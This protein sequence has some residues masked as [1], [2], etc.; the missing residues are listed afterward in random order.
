MFATSSTSRRN[1]AH[2]R[3]R[4]AKPEEIGYRSKDCSTSPS[5]IS[6]MPGGSGSRALSAWI[7]DSALGRRSD[8]ARAARKRNQ[9]ERETRCGSKQNAARTCQEGAGDKEDG[10]EREG[11]EERA[12]GRES[13]AGGEGESG[14]E[15]RKGC[16][17]AGRKGG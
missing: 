1:T 13:E 17:E 5:S 7:R 15:G 14:R 6:R 8:P 10:E 4:S 16:E 9:D 2:R 11:A 12:A 3:R